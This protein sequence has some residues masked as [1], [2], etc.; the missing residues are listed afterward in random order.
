MKVEE[1]K[2]LRI[3]RQPS[4]LQFMIDQKEL[5]NVEYFNYLGSVIT[6]DTRCTRGIKSRNAMAKAAFNRKKTL[7]TNKLDFNLRR[8][9]VKCCI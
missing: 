1:T 8:K 9:L 4:T 7:F 3:S 5:E 6:N 2:V